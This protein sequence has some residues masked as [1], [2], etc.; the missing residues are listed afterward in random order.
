MDKLFVKNE[1][2]M[3]RIIRV[4]V[5]I[6]LIVGGFAVHWLLFIPG[7]ILLATGVLGTCLIYS[8]VGVSTCPV[9]TKTE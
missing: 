7:V 2:N 1:G 4:I 3:D 5:G 6:A 8:L 9:D